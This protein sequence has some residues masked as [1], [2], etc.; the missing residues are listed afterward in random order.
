MTPTRY[1]GCGGVRRAARPVAWSVLVLAFAVSPGA[2]DLAAPRVPHVAQG[3]CPFEGCQYGT[4]IARSRLKAYKTEGD[5]SVVAFAIAPEERF[6]AIRGNVHVV[7]PGEV[8]VR[9]P[10]EVDPGRVLRR[11]DRLYVL[12]YRGAGRYELWHRGALFTAEAFWPPF[13]SMERA[14]GEITTWPEMLWWVLVKA[15]QGR[16]GW[17]RLRNVS[18]S[19]FEFNEPLCLGPC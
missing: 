14:A 12:S 17:L 18:R 9:R 11:G 8:R 6:Q 1:P 4:W 7:K 19:G 13:V 10:V 15:A 2:G 3:V 5:T 16:Q